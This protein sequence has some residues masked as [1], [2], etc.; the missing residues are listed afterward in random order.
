M[1]TSEL[2]PSTVT[3]TCTSSTQKLKD[4]V[5]LRPLGYSEPLASLGYQ[6]EPC[7]K[8]HT[9]VCVAGETEKVMCLIQIKI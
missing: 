5:N 6:G 2:K 3:H 7:P 4:C 9:C 1:H 8:T